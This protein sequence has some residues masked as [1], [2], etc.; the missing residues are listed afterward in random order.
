MTIWLDMRRRLEEREREGLLRRLVAIG[1][2]SGPT[3]EIGGRRV[4]CLSGNDYLGLAGDERVK[5]AAAEAIGQWGVGAG[6]SRLLGG[7]T[8]LHDELEA[9]LAAFKGAEAALVTST[10]W[11]ANH[12]A[13]HALAGRGDL[14][15]ADKLSHA[16]ILD[17]GLSSGATL[18]TYAHCDMK[19]LS[20]L[21]DRFRTKHRR[22]L[23]VTDSLF[24]MDGDVAPL[25]ELADLKDRHDAQLLIDEAHA[26]GVLGRR[27]AGAAEMLGVEGRIDATVGTLSKALGGLGGFVAGPRVLIDTILNTGRAF[28]FTTALPPALCAAALEALRIIRDEPQR[29]ARL[30][31]LARRLRERL[32]DMGLMEIRAGAAKRQAAA[33]TS[34]SA[35]LLAGRGE[36]N[37]VSTLGRN[38]CPT[39]LAGDARP[40]FSCT[41]IIP[42]VVGE[43]GAAVRLSR[44]MLEEGFY[45]PA[46]RPPTVPRGASRLRV[47]LRC[48]HD[49]ADLLRFAEALG[50]EVR[51]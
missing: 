12:V 51:G 4:V 21:L 30:L 42:I 14:I 19:R 41:P 20:S 47:S 44:R 46:I 1:S 31:E 13:I 23:I 37:L 8:K 9:S 48:D 39:G 45:V 24:S 11:G 16:S 32:T 34:A 43:A 10:G 36:E 29:R 18:R 6:A 50:K 25:G 33:R 3:V 7:T 28:I 2:G 27:G 22:C 40:T 15:L 38:S 5:S 35:A 26:T 49:E 17:A